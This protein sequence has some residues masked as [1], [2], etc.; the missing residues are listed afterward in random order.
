LSP[1][2]KAGFSLPQSQFV[3]QDFSLPRAH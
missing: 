2:R 1:G 3:E